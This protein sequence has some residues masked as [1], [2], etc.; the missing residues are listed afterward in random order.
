[1]GMK[2]LLVKESSV[3][4]SSGKMYGSLL[5][6]GI[7][8]ALLSFTMAPLTHAASHRPNDVMSACKASLEALGLK[9]IDLWLMHYPAANDPDTADDDIRVIDVPYTDTWKAM[10]EC[11]DAGLVRNIGVSSESSF[12]LMNSY[13]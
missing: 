1:M 4:A 2:L 8:S 9:Y 5:S 12:L 11:V 6:S 10:E 7:V 13:Q 3:Q